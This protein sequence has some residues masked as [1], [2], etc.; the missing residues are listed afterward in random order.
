V[1]W[2]ERITVDDHYVC[3]MPLTEG[4]KPLKPKAD[5]PVLVSDDEPLDPSELN[6]FHDAV[7]RLPLIIEAAFKA[8]LLPLLIDWLEKTAIFNFPII[9]P[10]RSKR[11]YGL[12]SAS[13]STNSSTSRPR[14]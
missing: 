5:Q 4:G 6:L 11:G 8:I 2:P 3:A 12:S 14:A 7:E 10:D 9:P 13:P 1:L